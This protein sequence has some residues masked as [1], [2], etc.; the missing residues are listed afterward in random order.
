MINFSV[1]DSHDIPVTDLA[2]MPASAPSVM[3]YVD[4]SHHGNS[5]SNHNNQGNHS[6]SHSNMASPN[7]NLHQGSHHSIRSVTSHSDR[8][9]RGHLDVHCIGNHGTL[10]RLRCGGQT[11]RCGSEPPE[12]NH[13]GNRDSVSSDIS[14]HN[15]TAPLPSSEP[16]Q[17]PFKRNSF[18][19]TSYRP[20]PHSSSPGFKRNHFQYSSYQ[21]YIRTTAQGLH[22]MYQ[23]RQQTN[24]A[25]KEWIE[26]MSDLRKDASN[27]N[28][29][30]AQ[31]TEVNNKNGR[32]SSPWQSRHNS[33]PEIS[34]T[35]DNSTPT[36]PKK[37][38]LDSSRSDSTVSVDSPSRKSSLTPLTQ[39]EGYRQSKDI[40]KS[41][42]ISPD[43][44][45][46]VSCLK[47]CVRPSSFKQ[48]LR[49]QCLNSETSQVDKN[50]HL[51]RSDHTNHKNEDTKKEQAYRRSGRSS[52]LPF[53]RV[54]PINKDIKLSSGGTDESRHM[55][56]TQPK[57]RSQGRSTWLSDNLMFAFY[58]I[59][60]IH[61][62]I[63]LFIFFLGGGGNFNTLRPGGTYWW[64]ST[65]RT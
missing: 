52:S 28:T 63:H 17:E 24:A 34:S 22:A 48:P 8:C 26:Q 31:R 61:L 5:M 7:N 41:D 65:R 2:A 51:N 58:F 16:P 4:T 43:T 9:M 25:S 1:S 40:H 38:N 36:F 50:N 57:A 23:A 54:S 49:S 37:L 30:P 12:D 44:S 33:I 53:C 15:I 13:Y 46:P 55:E 29:R 47:S 11:R 35:Y 19:Y 3:D 6:N 59:L 18:Q 39:V 32:S 64:V 60:F 45:T 20:P 14:A 10:D 62:F 42:I 21:G 27:N 56:N